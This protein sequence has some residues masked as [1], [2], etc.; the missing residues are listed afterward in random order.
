M[1]ESAC[2][3]VCEWG[4]GGV[5]IRHGVCEH[6][7]VISLEVKQDRFFNAK[8]VWQFK[9]IHVEVPPVTIQGDFLRVR[10]TWE[11]FSD[12]ST[13]LWIGLSNRWNPIIYLLHI[14]WIFMS[15]FSHERGGYVSNIEFSN[16]SCLIFNGRY[17]NLCNHNNYSFLGV[18]FFLFVPR[19]VVA[20]TFVI[21]LHL[22]FW[23]LIFFLLSFSFSFWFSVL[24]GRRRRR[25]SPTL[26]PAVD[27][28]SHRQE[29]VKKHNT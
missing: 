12:F 24:K 14:H 5:L 17:N 23:E 3:S 1:R 6:T 8:H 28:E 9:Y 25:T 11:N 2:V 7:T 26:L 10:L 21:S 19:Y 16:S 20:S 13:T 22:K 4:G 29:T 27:I 18:V 15:V